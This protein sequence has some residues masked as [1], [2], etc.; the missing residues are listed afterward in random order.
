MESNV[1]GTKLEHDVMM[2]LLRRW[3]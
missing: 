1:P 3:L 2:S